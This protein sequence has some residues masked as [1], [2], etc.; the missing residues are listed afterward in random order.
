[1]PK[2][3]ITRTVNLSN[4][5]FKYLLVF[6]IYMYSCLKVA[7]SICCLGKTCHRHLLPGGTM[8]RRNQ[9]YLNFTWVCLLT[10]NIF[11]AV[12]LKKTKPLRYSL[13]G[14]MNKLAKREDNSKIEVIV[15]CGILFGV[16]SVKSV[17][18]SSC[19][20]TVCTKMF[21][22]CASNI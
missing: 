18:F 20:C 16:F 17:E 15:L 11:G 1:M 14:N 4:T 2:L 5:Q 7:F 19:M 21:C 3:C 8:L 12:L 6:F 10:C 9:E 13:L 22:Y